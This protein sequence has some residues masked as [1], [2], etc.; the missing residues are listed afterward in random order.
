M[1]F[2]DLRVTEMRERRFQPPPQQ[3]V[4]LA[5]NV[6]VEPPPP[7]PVYR[8]PD[9]P[10][11][12]EDGPWRAEPSPKRPR[13]RPRKSAMPLVPIV[14]R[15][16]GRPRKNSMVPLAIPALNQAAT[17]VDKGEG[18]LQIE[19]APVPPSM[20]P[21]REIIGTLPWPRK[22][23]PT[24]FRATFGHDSWARALV[25]CF[26]DIDGNPRQQDM[27]AHFRYLLGVEERRK[28]L[29]LQKATLEYAIEEFLMEH[30]PDYELCKDQEIRKKGA[31]VE[32]SSST[33]TGTP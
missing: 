23:S 12:E 20:T 26:P 28:E 2:Y 3:V 11:L 10:P 30:A 4:N 14:K 25:Q 5:A 17:S 29:L 31:T 6:V 15:P 27:I 7:I 1:R 16:R 13:G 24:E 33:S 8:E 9:T 32:L 18:Q 22:L 19:D 21:N